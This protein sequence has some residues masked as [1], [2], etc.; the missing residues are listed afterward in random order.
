VGGPRGAD[1]FRLAIL[2]SVPRPIVSASALSGRGI[3]RRSLTEQIDTAKPEGKL[4]FHVFGARA[5]FERDQTRQ[6]PHAGL[7]AARARGRKGGRP[8]KLA[9]PKQ[10]VLARAFYDGGRADVATI[11]ATFGISRATLYR[12]LQDGSE[13]RPI[14]SVTTDSH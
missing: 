14:A 2:R 1:R 4:V 3:G 8:K 10:R 7:A 11:C 9:D 12:A 6:R 5:E 13:P